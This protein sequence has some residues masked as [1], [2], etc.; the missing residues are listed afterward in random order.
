MNENMN[1]KSQEQNQLTKYA[2]DL[3]KIYQAEKDK[4]IKLDHS[5]AQLRELNNHLQNMREKERAELSREVHDSI[6]QALT[7]LKL[8]VMWILKNIENTSD[9]VLTKFDGMKNL[10]D[11]TIKIVQKISTKLRPGILDDL[12]LALALEWQLDEFEKRTEIKCSFSQNPDNISISEKLSI[13]LFRIVQ[14]LLTNVARHSK[15]TELKIRLSKIDD[16]IELKI[17]DNGIGIKE[18]NIKDPK[19]LG[20]LGIN[21][22]VFAINGVAMFTGKENVGTEVRIIVQDNLRAK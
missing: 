12:G 1:E 17:I 10:I 8:D 13:G 16:T 9:E 4:R 19:S 3:V 14:E 18:E 21:E 6:G 5:R 7:A 2:E 15:A 20:L 11:D 22:R